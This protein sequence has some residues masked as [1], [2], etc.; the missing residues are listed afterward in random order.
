MGFQPC[1]PVALLDN[2]PHHG[3]R[4]SPREKRMSGTTEADRGNGK[5]VGGAVRVSV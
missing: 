2:R 3:A 1:R 5:H 4:Q